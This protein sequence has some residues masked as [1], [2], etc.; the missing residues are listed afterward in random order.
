MK[1]SLGLTGGWPR[2]TATH[3]PMAAAVISIGKSLAGADWTGDEPASDARIRAQRER[4]TMP[5]RMKAARA[6]VP[7][8]GAAVPQ[9]TPSQ[10]LA[11]AKDLSGELWMSAHYRF[12]AAR[13]EFMRA[14]TFAEIET[15]YRFEGSFDMRPL[16]ADAWSALDA[17]AV[18]ERCAIDPYLLSNKLG[19]CP[20][21]VSRN[22][23]NGYLARRC[24]QQADTST[25]AR[26][27]NAADSQDAEN[28][29]K[30]R[31][32]IR[33]EATRHLKDDN[34]ITRE[35]L[36]E[37]LQE[38]WPGLTFNFLRNQIWGPSRIDA[39]LSSDGLVGKR[40]TNSAGNSASIRRPKR[41]TYRRAL[42]RRQLPPI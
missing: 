28:L 42:Y 37:L 6:G 17:D 38:K 9:R 34:K 10:W 19:G 3:V 36:H 14:A 26:K 5:F 39:G 30:Q 1:Q 29:R 21:F 2:E 27:I 22:S 25:S 23:L 18:F 41:R 31:K 20:V 13:E 8:V 4:S 12:M 7:F 11:A 15:F 40:K 24:S 16:H 32:A 33:T 35:R